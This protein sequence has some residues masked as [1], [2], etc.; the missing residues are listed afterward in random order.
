[1]TTQRSFNDLCIENGIVIKTSQQ[2]IKI[3]A[4]AHW[5]SCLP[6]NLKRYCPQL[7]YQ[8]TKENK[9]FYELEYLP[10]LPLN[11]LYVHGSLPLTFWRKIFK[12]ANELLNHFNLSP[13]L[14]EDAK[15]KIQLDFIKLLTDKTEKRLSKYANESCMDINKPT[16][17]NKKVLPSLS[18]IVAECQAAAFKLPAKPG[19]LHGDFCFSNILYDSRSDSLKLLDPRG[20]DANQEF[21]IYG[22]LRYDIAKFSHSVIGGYDHIIAGLFTLKEVSPLNFEFEIHVDDISRSI[23]GYFEKYN[24]L[25]ISIRDI[26]PLVTLL[27]ISMLPLHADNPAR[28]R[29]FLAN[30]LRIYTLWKEKKCL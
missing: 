26:L 12:L 28:Q 16:E 2:S 22:D 18:H 23:I 4:E 9:Y 27:F 6:H 8:G 30:S 7:I 25:G 19:I 3:Q 17:F 24:L 20:M 13:S 29:A 5:F 15:S 11:E 10:H 21:T 1:M 14:L